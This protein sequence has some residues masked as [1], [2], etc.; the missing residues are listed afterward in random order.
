MNDP[1]RLSGPQTDSGTPDRSGIGARRAL[2]WT[3]LVVSAAGNAVTSMS[4]LPVAVSVSCG[5]VTILC[6]VA[7][8]AD[9][10]KRRR[11]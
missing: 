5:V 11:A 8:L 7:L 4:G 3:V 10:S 6:I 9:W 2:L 1:Y